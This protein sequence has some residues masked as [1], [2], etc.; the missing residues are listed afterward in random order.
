MSTSES[1]KVLV[2]G[3]GGKLGG[4]LLKE[5]AA[6]GYGVRALTRDPCTFAGEDLDVF[7]CDARRPDSSRRPTAREASPHTSAN[8]PRARR[9]FECRALTS[10]TP[11]HT[12]HSRPSMTR[13]GG[14]APAG[15][16]QRGLTF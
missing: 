15:L 16:P 7:G 2:A 12:V 11:R 5:L 6:R 8:S 1:G 14:V 4:H 3:A 10:P 9:T 13:P